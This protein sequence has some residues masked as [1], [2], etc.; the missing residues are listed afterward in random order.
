M[1]V[2][3][4]FPHTA[5]WDSVGVNCVSCRHFSGPASWPDS[6]RVSCCRLHGLS[7]A[8]QLDDRGFVDGEWFCRDF[9]T[10]TVEAPAG[11]LKRV[12]TRS[13]SPTSSAAVDHLAQIRDQ[14]QASVV[15]G[16][17]GRDGN[18]QERPFSELPRGCTAAD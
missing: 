2:R 18:L 15:Y 17:Y 4:T 6:D 10:P 7:L 12:F 5:R 8:F 3:D 16:F 13:M 1:P 11:L 14:L 9:A